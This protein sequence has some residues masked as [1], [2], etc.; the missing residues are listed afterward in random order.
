MHALSFSLSLSH[1][2]AL[3]LWAA[4]WTD[5]C[6]WRGAHSE[7][8]YNNIILWPSYGNMVLLLWRNMNIMA[9]RGSLGNYMAVMVL[10]FNRFSIYLGSLGAK[11][12]KLFTFAVICAGMLYIHTCEIVQRQSEKT[13]LEMPLS[14]GHSSGGVAWHTS[15]Y[16]KGCVRQ[17]V[18][19]YSKINTQQDAK[20]AAR[21]RHS[22]QLTT[23]NENDLIRRCFIHYP[24]SWS[25]NY[26]CRCPGCWIWGC[27]PTC[28]PV[29]RNLTFDGQWFALTDQPNDL[30]HLPKP[31]CL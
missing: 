22:S 9:F 8:A 6:H 19:W 10:S 3:T 25:C 13:R 2:H 5:P 27:S 17:A 16:G 29:G 15:G 4:L 31:S 20:R 11:S 18:E 1:T 7:L 21:V 30:A 24:P 26:H 28:T 12:I 14:E 23:S